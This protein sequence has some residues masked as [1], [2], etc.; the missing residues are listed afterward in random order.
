MRPI[1]LTMEGFLSFR[2]SFTLDFDEFTDGKF[3]LDGETGAGKTAIFDAICFA[4]YGKGTGKRAS[5]ASLHC[6]SLNP[7]EFSTVELTFEHSERTY[8]ICRKFNLLKSQKK[9]EKDDEYIAI[10]DDRDKRL[11]DGY[12]AVSEYVTNLLNVN[13][14]QFTQIVMLP[15]GQFKEFLLAKPEDK[16]NILK[17]INKVDKYE[18]YSELLKD[19]YYTISED[20][21]GYEARINQLIGDSDLNGIPDYTY[22]GNEGFAHNLEELV[23]SDKESF[24]QINDKHDKKLGKIKNYGS[25]KSKIKYVYEA[26]ESL[27]DD[28]KEI[29]DLTDSIGNVEE[30][31]DKVMKVSQYCFNIEPEIKTRSDMLKKIKD[32]EGIITKEKTTL[33]EVLKPK[34]DEA[35]KAV[36]DD[37]PVADLVSNVQADYELMDNLIKREYVSEDVLCWKTPDDEKCPEL[38]KKLSEARSSVDSIVALDKKRADLE[39]NQTII[40]DNIK[41]IGEMNNTFIDISKSIDI[42]TGRNEEY[43][44]LL[45]SRDEAENEYNRNFRLFVESQ[46][47][48][49]ADETKSTLHEKGECDCP[50]CGMHLTLKSDCRF[51]ENTGDTVDEKKL[52]SYKEKMNEAG[53]NAES[54][55]KRMIDPLDSEITA[56]KRVLGDKAHGHFDDISGFDALSADYFDKKRAACE[57]EL[58]TVSQA[59]EQVKNTRVGAVSIVKDHIEVLKAKVS[60]LRSS[61]EARANYERE[62]EKEYNEQDIMI[63]N[64]ESNCSEYSKACEEAEGKLRKLIDV[65]CI[66]DEILNSAGEIMSGIE[67]REVWIQEKSQQVAHYNDLCRS[68]EENQEKVRDG[69]KEITD[70][71]DSIGK[72]SYGRNALFA[73]EVKNKA[74]LADKESRNRLSRIIDKV[75]IV[76]DSKEYQERVD[77]EFRDAENVLKSHE[78]LHEKITECLGH[79]YATDEPATLLRSLSELADPSSGEGG[80]LSFTRFVMG[81]YFARVLDRANDRLKVMSDDRF[82]ML[83]LTTAKTSKSPAGVDVEIYD[84]DD[85][86]VLSKEQLSGG[87]GFIVSLALALGMS[88]V[89]QEN[90]SSKDN[91][92][93]AVLKSLFIDEGFGTLDNDTLDI[94]KNCLDDLTTNEGRLVGIIT[95][96]K[97]FDIAKKV[98]I[99]YSKEEHTSY[100]DVK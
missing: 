87:Q 24:N 56:S 6:K 92:E 68:K 7:E 71:L 18:R 21:E 20:R 69:S 44:K 54:Y 59:I 17:S 75:S 27:E 39:D 10:D 89:A 33:E 15:Q 65:E 49:L 94:V 30:L 41:A 67:N 60:E 77:R 76:V 95:H 45:S 74:L 73:D 37:R 32:T 53:E 19:A 82:K 51:A 98:V 72:L 78:E 16:Y 14:E 11:A 9:N 42:L 2:E 28:V 29:D 96:I 31:N 8:Y 23:S 88:D 48:I 79:L 12:G 63:K 86:F 26:I 3:I 47:Y 93:G 55:K 70:L 22:V 61:I 83:L 13:F 50:V 80:K 66:T 52:L 81:S 90:A 100:R 46:A 36:S 91:K 85:G 25:L 99:K 34:L 57:K 4:L 40:K 64:L 1:K 62:C 5:K 35:K 84:N 97:D 43:S 58:M 38:M